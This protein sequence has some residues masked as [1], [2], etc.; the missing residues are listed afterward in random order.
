MT[1]K[2]E[3]WLSILPKD[4][5]PWLLSSDEPSARF[6]TMTAVLGMSEDDADVRNARKAVVA[7]PAVRALVDRLPGWESGFT[8][9]G[10]NSP[11]FPPNLLR[12]LHGLGVRPGDFTA[13]E[14]LLDRMA[15]H[16]A[17]DGRYLTPGGATGKKDGAATWA[18]LPCDHFAILEVLLLFGRR[19]APGIQRGLARVRDTL[20][21]TTQ[22][23]AWR[24]I[25]DPVARWRGPGRKNDA[26]LQVTVEALRLFS[27]VPGP[28]RPKR[29]GEAARTLLRAWRCRAEEK[30]YMFGHGRRFVAGKWPPTWYDASAVLEA[31][32]PFPSVWKGKAAS[33]EDR[34]SV[35][36][37][38]RGLASTVRPDGG[39]IPQSCYKG[40]ESYSFGQKKLPSP[41]ATARLC[42][43]LRAFSPILVDPSHP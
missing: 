7:D 16:Q 20:D 10:H 17:D 6:V 26:C 35:A 2:R 36:E 14:R 24:C 8:F 31:V 23:I 1:T 34:D 33:A 37:I 9:S 18:S 27:L 40:F 4:P 19:A 15:L 11:G 39:V 32:A 28:D 22:G 43:F 3:A 38:A 29:I 41:W 13:I 30:P 5:R 42:G 25:P 21:D 12:L